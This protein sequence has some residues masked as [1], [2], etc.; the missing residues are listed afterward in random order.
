[1]TNIEL[2]IS[3]MDISEIAYELYKEDWIGK[4]TTTYQRVKTKRE[5]LEYRKEC[6]DN[7]FEIDAFEEWI[8]DNG[9]SGTLY[10]CY[11]EFCEMEYHDKEY[12]YSLLESEELIA[13][14]HSDIENDNEF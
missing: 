3:E 6:I 13:M 10:V 9:Y 14:Y 1:M 2:G 7:D 11:E 12:M 8:W 4:Y 5:Y